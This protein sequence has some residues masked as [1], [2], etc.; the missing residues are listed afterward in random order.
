MKKETIAA[1]VLAIVAVLAGF[2]YGHYAHA[3]DGSG[4]E[5]RQAEQVP[6]QEII[7]EFVAWS[8]DRRWRNDLTRNARLIWGLD[9]PVA[10]F[11]AQIKQESGW[12]PQAVSRVGAQGM[13]QFMPATARWWCELRGIPPKDCVPGNPIWAMRSLIGYDQWLFARVSADTPC[14]KMAMAL[15]AY[16]GGLGWVYKDQRL[17]SAWGVAEGKW[18]GHV[19]KFN[20]GRH[21]ANFKENRDYPKKILLA[22]QISYLDWGNPMCTDQIKGA[23]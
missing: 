18:W 16:N 23:L 1:I 5:P 17:A 8:K 4:V 15:S 11:A 2:L 21:P 10:V 7:T 6:E 13:A 14:D 20:A 3:D 22:H 9:A 19:E 12:N